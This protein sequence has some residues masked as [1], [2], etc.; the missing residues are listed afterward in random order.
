MTFT[1]LLRHVQQG[2][3]D[4]LAHQDVPFEMLVDEI[5]PERTLSHSPLTSVV[6]AFQNVPAGGMRLADIDVTSFEFERTS[7]QFNLCLFV[8]DAGNGLTLAAE[9]SADL[10][11]EST[12]AHM[13]RA[14]K[15]CLAEWRPI[16]I[17]PSR[18]C[19]SPEP[20]SATTP[21]IAES[22]LGGVSER[23]PHR[24]AL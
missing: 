9:Y 18:R 3:L 10:F 15:R 22:D 12:I 16:R 8:V 2:V 24:R 13:L 1:N 20:T 4:A 19:L 11:E 17:L 21:S 14:F 23:M 7:A 6:F 5:R